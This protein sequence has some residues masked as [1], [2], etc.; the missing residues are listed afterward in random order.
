MI[1]PSVF[2][3]MILGELNGEAYKKQLI[4]SLC[5]SRCRPEMSYSIKSL[6]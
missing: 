5:S 4:N 3:L 2:H 6:V 1:M